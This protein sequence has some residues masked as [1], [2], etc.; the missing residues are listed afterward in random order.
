MKRFV[1][2]LLFMKRL[3]SCLLII[4]RLVSCFLT[5]IL[6]FNF[7]IILSHRTGHK[8]ILDDLDLDPAQEIEDKNYELCRPRQ[9][10]EGLIKEWEYGN[11]L[12]RKCSKVPRWNCFKK[13]SSQDKLVA[14]EKFFR[15]ILQVEIQLLMARDLMETLLAVRLISMRLPHH[16]E[17]PNVTIEVRLSKWIILFYCHANFVYRIILFYLIITQK[18]RNKS[19]IYIFLFQ[20]SC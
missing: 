14:F 13:S 20:V 1:S 4:K 9:E 3:V 12:I 10:I 7:Q 17:H 16:D 2:Y 19:Y 11:K 8:P 18:F 5:T 6:I 15:R